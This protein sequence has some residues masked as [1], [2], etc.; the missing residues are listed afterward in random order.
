MVIPGVEPTHHKAI[1]ESKLHNILWVDET[2]LLSTS[3]YR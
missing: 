1:E 2:E 3:S